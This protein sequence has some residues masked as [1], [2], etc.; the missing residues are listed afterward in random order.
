MCQLPQYRD[1]NLIVGIESSDDSAVYRL[2]DNTAIVSTL[3]FFPPIVDDPYMFGQIAAA[4]A[5]SD[6]YAMGAKPLFATNIVCFPPK[7]SKDIL[8]EILK[9][10]SDKLHD[11]GIVVAGG[12]SVEDEEVKYGLSITGIINPK[13]VVTNKDARVGDA[14]ILTKPLGTGVIASALKSE[15]ITEGEVVEA[16]TSMCTLNDV[17]SSVMTDFDVSSC[18]DVTGFGL[19]GHAL[20][21]TKGSGLTLDINSK[22]LKVFPEAL[23]LV[24]NKKNRPKSIEENSLYLKGEISFEGDISKELEMIMFDPQTSGGLLISV[25]EK[26]K[27]ELLNVLIEK[28]IHASEI[29]VFKN[30]SK[31]K[32]SPKITVL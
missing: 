28:G 21:M 10:S 32:N 18:T 24:K 20:E 19:L 22:E 30:N 6:I 25:S 26:N 31:E 7:L 9:G 27:D 3:D 12:H 11:A 14:L 8:V 4:N 1:D 2:D 13:V 29:G 16:L 23:E 5:L 15:T 17:A